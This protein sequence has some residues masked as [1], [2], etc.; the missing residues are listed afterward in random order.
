MRDG[1]RFGDRSRIVVGVETVGTAVTPLR[2][3]AGEARRAGALLHVV[4]VAA[5]RP[6]YHDR[7][8]GWSMLDLALETA[9]PREGPGVPVMRSVVRG[10]P[11]PALC[12][13]ARDAS[14]LVVGTPAETHPG[15]RM[16][17]GSVSEY[18]IRHSP[19]PVVIV[20][21]DMVAGPRRSEWEV[22]V[23]PPALP[24]QAQLI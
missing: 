14:L 6:D 16:V 15:Q 21:F 13:T 12:K 5:P 19:V 7:T 9:F 17:L 1:Y 3:A 24:D 10:Q 2:W 22:R 23:N 20:R 4:H 18:C 11:G 8:H